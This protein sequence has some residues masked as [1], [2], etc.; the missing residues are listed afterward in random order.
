MALD[1]QM[2]RIF[3]TVS[4]ALEDRRKQQA[5]AMREGVAQRVGL[6]SPQMA[7]V[8][9]KG[10]DA[11]NSQMQDLLA[12]LLMQQRGEERQ[13]MLTE[14][15]WERQLGLNRMNSQQQMRY[16]Q[17]QQ[18]FSAQENE[19][20]RGFTREGWDRQDDMME[21]QKKDAAKSAW[22][23]LLTSTG[24]G[25]LTGGLAPAALGAGSMLT[26]GLLGG[27]MG[28]AN[29]AG[30]VGQYAGQQSGQKN[31]IDFLNQ[32]SNKYFGGSK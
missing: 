10:I 20:Q 1:P 11:S 25:A 4:R 2:R 26:G 23:K 3:D 6:R 29:T 8:E 9:Q 7:A 22:T 12:N 18:S 19:K 30:M 32:Y 16:L 15:E 21:Q 14:E 13:D 24:I 31:M 17:E 28:G 5:P 27:A